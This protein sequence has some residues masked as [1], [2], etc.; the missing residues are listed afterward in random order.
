[1]LLAAI[2]LEFLGPGL[3]FMFA[4]LALFFQHP[5]PVSARAGLAAATLGAAITWCGA[6]FT[7]LGK[8]S[9]IAEW[10]ARWW[11]YVTVAMLGSCVMVSITGPDAGAARLALVIPLVTGIYHGVRQRWA[12]RDRPRHALV[13]P[14]VPVFRTPS[15][16]ATGH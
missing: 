16:L 11:L 8:E 5:G 3:A 15:P 13:K 7:A 4:G 10:F 2:T 6:R 9:A 14:Y 1:M 12:Q